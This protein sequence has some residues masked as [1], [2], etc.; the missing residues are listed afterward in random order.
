MKVL[1]TYLFLIIDSIVTL[2]SKVDQIL[3]LKTVAKLTIKCHRRLKCD[4]DH[5]CQ[6]AFEIILLPK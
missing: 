5:G 2:G 4:F 3:V 6:I 1:F